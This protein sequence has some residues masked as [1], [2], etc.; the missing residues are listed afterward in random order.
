[1]SAAFRQYFNSLA[2]E[3]TVDG[4]RTWLRSRLAVHFVGFAAAMTADSGWQKVLAESLEDGQLMRAVADVLKKVSS[5]I[6]GFLRLVI[7]LNFRPFI[8]Y[9][10]L[11]SQ[12]LNAFFL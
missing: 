5:H 11:K 7:F 9:F 6:T 2:D 10:S 8:V 12:F 4:S 1:M 3:E